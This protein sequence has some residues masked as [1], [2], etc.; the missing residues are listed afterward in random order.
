MNNKNY[1]RL[2]D[3]E[4][5]EELNAINT[6]NKGDIS[7]VK[8]DGYD[9][10]FNGKKWKK[11]TLH[12]GFAIG[13]AVAGLSL[14][15]AVA[16]ALPVTVTVVSNNNASN[17]TPIEEPVT[18]PTTDSTSKDNNRMIGFNTNGGTAVD[19]IV[20]EIGK[21]VTAP[22]APTKLGGFK[23]D[24][25]YSDEGLTN[26]YTF[27]TMPEDNIT[28]Y[29]KWAVVTYTVTF[30]LGIAAE[31]VDPSDFDPE[32]QL[33]NF[34]EKVTDPG[35]YQFIKGSTRYELGYWYV[36]GVEDSF[37]NSWDFESFIV[38]EDITLIASWYLVDPL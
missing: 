10:R 28:L 20:A 4:T 21:T 32:T 6:P 14:L 15:T 5:L 22:T 31:L 34:G 23:F 33:H 25:W 19:P 12:P 30:D 11:V 1:K 13:W 2:K 27:S 37:L 16:I 9:Y 36:S 24:G 26:A 35:Y 17:N 8:E 7:F 18:N 3:N 29:A 38:L